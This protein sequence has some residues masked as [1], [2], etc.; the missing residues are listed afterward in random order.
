MS[1]TTSRT[2]DLLSLLQTHRHWPCR[3]LA[4]RLDVSERTLRRDIERLRELG[5]GVEATRGAVGG[6][7]LEAGTGIPPL[8]LTDDEGVAIAVGLRSQAAAGI[9]DSEHTT[10]SALAKIEQVLPAALRRRI[11]A[12][13]SH[14][15]II[16]G[17][18][19]GVDAEL[20]AQ[21]ALSCR[22][23]ERIRFAYTDA[24]G[25]ESTRSTEPHMLVPQGR[26]WYL[27]AWDRDR[28]DWRTF[29]LDRISGLAQTR[30]LF[31]SRDLDAAGAA[32][33]VAKSVS[34]RE[35]T[36]TATVTIDLP[37]AD[38]QQALGWWARDAYAAPATG[39]TQRSIWPLTSDR[40]TNL[41][42]ALLWIPD[43]VDYSVD[44]SAEVLEYLRRQATRF[45]ASA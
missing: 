17:Q 13:Q 15:A 19:P 39:T 30:V 31:P 2:L 34:W 29:R 7:R 37:I 21:L 38:L 6:Y 44:G 24:R 36:Y 33:L 4:G 9:R 5:Y 43:D 32:A 42:I 11:E 14:A 12:L 45:T 25:A 20:L 10:L 27:V 23:S 18:G 3:E 40:L 1:D 8:L 35:T 41:A 26:R 22:D 28:D 16:P